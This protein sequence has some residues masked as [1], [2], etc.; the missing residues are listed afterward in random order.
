M[1]F[2]HIF[3]IVRRTVVIFHRWRELTGFSSPH[4]M[5][6]FRQAVMV[7]LGDPVRAISG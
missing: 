2:L 7:Q 3:K 6:L 1:Q 4:L 5:R